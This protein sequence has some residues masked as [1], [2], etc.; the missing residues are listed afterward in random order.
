[1][2]KNTDQ[3]F[4]HRFIKSVKKRFNTYIDKNGHLIAY[5]VKGEDNSYIAKIRFDSGPNNLS[6]LMN[7]VYFDSLIKMIDCKYS[8][9]E[10]LVREVQDIEN[11]LMKTFNLV[12][13]YYSEDHEI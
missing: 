8:F 9:A 4:Y 10:V 2:V 13:P 1:M 3:D 6:V 5:E 12:K 7:F 11:D